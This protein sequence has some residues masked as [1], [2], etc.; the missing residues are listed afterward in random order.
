[1]SDTRIGPFAQLRTHG[2]RFL[3]TAELE[4]LG[5]EEN[6][7]LGPEALLRVYPSSTALGSTRNFLGL[8]SGAAMT[9][10]LG[11]GLARLIATNRL[12]YAEDGRHDADVG[13]FARVTSPRVSLGRLTFD[14]LVRDRYEN[15]LNR[16]FDLG[17]D[18]RLR[19]YPPA[20]FAYSSRGPVAVALNTEARTRSID[21][22]S[23]QVGLAAFY[24]VGGASETFGELYLRQSVGFGLRFLFP[25]ADRT[26]LRLDWAFPFT[27]APGYA[28]FP[29]AFSLAF[30]QAFSMPGLPTPTVMTPDT[31]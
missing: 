17:G 27:P 18:S 8:L 30:D 31:R 24:D 22:L 4:T 28:T 2:Q 5:L 20:G 29:G 25:Q 21:I 10:A 11:D 23:A 19:G 26:V 15:Y 13:V 6:Y 3:R 7:R 1:L 14:G 9:A 16:S 12:E